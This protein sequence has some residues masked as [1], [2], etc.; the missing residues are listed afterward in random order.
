MSYTN[1]S[2]VFSVKMRY[3]VSVDVKNTLFSTAF[4][5]L[6]DFVYMGRESVFTID[7]RKLQILGSN[8]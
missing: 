4:N 6:L 8:L 5:T 1:V 2:C 7:M 3:G